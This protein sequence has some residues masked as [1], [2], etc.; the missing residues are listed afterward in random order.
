MT[1]ETLFKEK[2]NI[3]IP[4]CMR[5]GKRLLFHFADGK[6]DCPTEKGGCGYYS[7]RD[8]KESKPKK[9]FLERQNNPCEEEEK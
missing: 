5:C 9:S 2:E 8:K 3:V 7:P 1:D 6:W 4:K